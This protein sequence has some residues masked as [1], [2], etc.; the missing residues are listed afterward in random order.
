MS[1]VGFRSI[2]V[3]VA[4]A[5][6]LLARNVPA[7]VFHTRESALHAA[8]PEADRIESED[9]IVSDA[10]AAEIA[11]RSGSPPGTQLV[12][13][14]AAYDGATRLGWAFFDTHVV[15]TLP[16][17]LLIA[18]TPEGRVASVR[19]VAFHEP[20]EYGPPSR[21]L[22]QFDEQ[23][24]SPRLAVDSDVDGISGATL[25]ARAITASVRRHLALWQVR[26]PSVGAAPAQPSGAP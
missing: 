13:A 22:S 24:L 23:P 10:E 20:P 19:L 12:T 8:F 25:T 18:L 17:T 1:S 9:W 4:L 11:R 5:A 26:L 7:E 3:A 6:L 2:P 14:Y 21:W 15:R 16:E